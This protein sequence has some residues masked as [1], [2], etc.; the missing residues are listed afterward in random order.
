M[1][2][3][4]ALFI[5]NNIH[6][7]ITGYLWKHVFFGIFKGFSWVILTTSAERWFVVW[8]TFDPE[9]G[10]DIFLRNVC[11]HVNYTALYIRRWQQSC[12]NL[13]IFVFAEKYQL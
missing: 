9:D 12:I 6:I 4:D 3:V 7:S 2:Y 13:P 10:D 5:I 11:S 8:L 1:V